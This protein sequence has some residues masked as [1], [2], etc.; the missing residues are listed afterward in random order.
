MRILYL[1]H[2]IPYPPNKGEKIRAFHQLRALVERHEVDLFTLADRESDEKYKSEL[3][4]LCRSVTTARIVPAV[5]RLRAIPS[6]FSRTPLTLPYF[7]S[8]DLSLQI[9]KAVCERSYDRV[10]VYSSSMAQYAALAGEVPVLI[11]LV[12]VDSDKWL[13]YA[14]HSKFPWSPLYQR[15]GKCLREYE[16]KICR[17]AAAVLVST[18]REAQLLRSFCRSA[19]VHV[20]PNGVNTDY[21]TPS[22]VKLVFDVP[23]LIFTGAMDYFPNIQA[24][25]FFSRQ[26]LPLIQEHLPE[27]Q[28]LIVGSNPATGVKRL[29]RIPGVEVTGYVPDVRSYLA[30]AHIFVAPLLIAT[31]IQNKIL[32]AMAMELPVVASNLAVQG[33]SRSVATCVE[34]A[35]EPDEFAN[36]VLGLSQNPNLLRARAFEARKAVVREYSWSVSLKTLVSLVENLGENQS[37]APALIPVLTSR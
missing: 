15:E 11:D 33:L 27:T 9:R 35:T 24:V 20:V 8:A 18:E 2:R 32:E 36:R 23:T 3:M 34:T 6:L 10:F 4:Q 12:D 19:S 1:C 31:G 29:E 37:S 7:Y 17:S 22:R 26:V 14:A 28:F 16:Q 30:R 21:F 25:T 13:Q 5:A